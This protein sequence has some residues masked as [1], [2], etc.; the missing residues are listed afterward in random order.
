[1]ERAALLLFAVGVAAAPPPRA[2]DVDHYDVKIA[3]DIGAKSLNGEVSI[4]FHSATDGLDSLE[5]DAG[6]LHVTSVVED[7]AS[8]RFERRGEL[9]V[10]QLGNPVRLGQ[11]RAISIRYDAGPAAGLSFFEDQVYSAYFTSHWMVCDD[12]PDDRATLRLTI[13][14]PASAKVAAS[15]RLVKTHREGPRAISEWRQDAEVPPFVFGFAVGDFVESMVQ[16]DRVKLRYLGKNDTNTLR[17]IFQNTAPALR[18][19]SE[20]SGMPYP[21]TTYT[22]ILAR[23]E[24]K[25]EAAAFTLLPEDYGQTLLSHPDDLWLLVHEFAHQWYGIGIACRDWSDFWLNEGLAT[26]LADVFLEQQFG[27][28]RYQHEVEEA[29]RIYEQL[30]LA[31]RD[32]P[33]SFHGWNTA[34]EAGGQLPYYKGAWVLHLLRMQM[35]EDAF[36]RGLRVYTKDNWGRAVTSRDFQKSMEAASTMNLSDFF[37]LWVY[38]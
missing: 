21:G 5:L 17:K 38:H 24:P 12:R 34:R 6:A 31:G 35:G 25:Q 22:Q 10:V 2:Y 15:G 8:L 36:W 18:F 29:R 30:K 9:L 7:F 20:K 27:R 28:E 1:V 16:S 13:S 33:L 19:L 32:R 23:R 26:F 11:E 14:A 37:D 3:P 4:Q